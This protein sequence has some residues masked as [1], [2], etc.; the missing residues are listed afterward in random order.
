MHIFVVV[1]VVVVVVVVTI[2]HRHNL[3]HGDNKGSKVFWRGRTQQ[4]RE[5]KETLGKTE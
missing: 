4:T 5:K 3:F 2:V 1:M